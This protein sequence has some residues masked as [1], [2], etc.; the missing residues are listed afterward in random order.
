MGAASEPK[1]ERSSW[2]SPIVIRVALHARMQEQHVWAGYGMGGRA[3]LLEQPQDTR[4]AMA[5]PGRFD[6]CL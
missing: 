6:A 5:W 1:K 4:K 2:F 3:V